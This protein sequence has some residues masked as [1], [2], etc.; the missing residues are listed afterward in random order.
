MIDFKQQHAEEV[1]AYAMKILSDAG[2][3]CYTYGGEYAN[4]VMDDLKLAFPYGMKFPYIE[5]ANAILAMSRPPMIHRAPFS[6]VWDTDDCCDAYG[7]ESLDEA[8]NR[9]L[10]VF[11]DWEAEEL[12]AMECS[13]NP[14]QDDKDDWNYML[15]TYWAYVAQYN[16]ETDE[17]E[18]IWAPDDNDL[19]LMGWVP[20]EE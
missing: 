4:K 13:E 15:K 16:P 14:T 7:A 11:M 17:Y 6:V 5:V 10:E 18:E 2:G 8:K 19:L 12:S 1:S 3:N 20:Y 9:C